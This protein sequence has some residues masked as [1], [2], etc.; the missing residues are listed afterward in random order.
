AFHWTRED[1]APVAREFDRLFERLGLRKNGRPTSA[2]GAGTRL[3]SPEATIGRELRAQRRVR[4]ALELANVSHLERFGTTRPARILHG[5]SA[6]HVDMPALLQ[7]ARRNR[8]SAAEQKAIDITASGAT[9]GAHI[10]YHQGR[11]KAPA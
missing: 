10:P 1:F 8:L 3:L 6:G 9:P 5:V 2:P 11:L 4:D 7:R